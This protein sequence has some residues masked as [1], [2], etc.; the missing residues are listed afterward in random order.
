MHAW[1]IGF[2]LNVAVEKAL[3]GIGLTYFLAPVGVQEFQQ[4]EGELVR[5]R[6]KRDRKPLV[7]VNS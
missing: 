3:L 5:F 1:V 4:I 6:S 2:Y 7:N